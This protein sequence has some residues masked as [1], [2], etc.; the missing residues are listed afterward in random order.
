MRSRAASGWFTFGVR[1]FA[2]ALPLGLLIAAF[3][4]VEFARMLGVVA[5]VGSMLGLGISLA[6]RRLESS[7]VDRGPFPS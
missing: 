3:A 6:G 5:L 1:L 2:V 7:G 4:P